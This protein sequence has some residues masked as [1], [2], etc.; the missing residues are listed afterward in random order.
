MGERIRHELHRRHGAVTTV[1]E[2]SP[3]L[4]RI[5]IAL[6]P[7]SAPVPH[8]P[9]AVGDHVKLAFPHPDTGELDLDSA[10]RPVLRD[11]TIRA[12]SAEGQLVVDVVVHGEGPGSSWAQGATAGTR[13]GV[14]G[15]RGSHLM[16]A[17]RRRY[18]VLA[19]E[20]A[21]PAAARWLEEAPEDAEVHVV[22]ETS[23]G[24]TAD[25]P[26]R[27]QSSV[28]VVNATGGSGLVQALLSLEPQRGDFLWAAG[29]AGAMLAV[30]KAVKDLHLDRDDVE[31]DGYWK[32]GVAGRDHHA[33]LDA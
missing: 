25:L 28:T 4:R 2:L 31:I 13:V 11:Y 16:P 29:E 8:L 20:S 14:L 30:R 5:G 18:L 15:P 22:I 26:R 3:R 12:V 23:D 21:H 6:D 33:P 24:A 7:G 17:D 32:Q 10:E 1:E 19:D 27:Q 9:L